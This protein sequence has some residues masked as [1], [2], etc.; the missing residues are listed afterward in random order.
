MINTVIKGTQTI[1]EYKAVRAD[2]Q[3]RAALYSKTHMSGCETW[4]HGKPVKCWRIDGDGLA[5]EY[6]DGQYW[7]YKQTEHGL[8]WW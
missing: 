6:E 1:A 7:Q 4:E 8:E 5:I 2:M 3:K